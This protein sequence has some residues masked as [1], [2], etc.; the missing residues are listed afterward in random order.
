MGKKQSL[1]DCVKAWQQDFCLTNYEVA[2]MCGCSERTYE[3]FRQGVCDNKTL[4]TLLGL[5]CGLETSESLLERTG[6][7]FTINLEEYDEF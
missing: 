2:T 5:L 1:I 6:M 7:G 4:A 3:R